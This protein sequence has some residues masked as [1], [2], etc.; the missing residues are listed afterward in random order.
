M[1]SLSAGYTFGATETVTNSKLA[2]LVNDGGVTG[3]TQA[4]I[5]AA[6]GLVKV[7]TSA[8]S[9]TDQL[10]ID[11]NSTPVLVRYYN[12]SLTAWVP[13]GELALYTNNS[14]QTGS[15]GRVLILDTSSSNA[16]TYTTTSGDTKFLGV[17]TGSITNGSSAPVVSHGNATVLLTVSAS[18]GCYLRTATASG[19]ADPVVNTAAGVFGFVTQA[20]TASARSHIFG[21]D[22]NGTIDQTANYTWTGTHTHNGTVTLSSAVTATNWNP[23]IQIVTTQAGAASALGNTALPH[24]DSIPQNT[25]GNAIAALDTSITPKNTANILHIEGAVTFTQS[26]ASDFM[27]LALFQDSTAGALRATTVGPVDLGASSNQIRIFHRMA[28]GTTSSTTF[29]LRIG[30]AGGASAWANAEAGGNNQVF[31][32]VAMSYLRVMETRT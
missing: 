19:K 10:W 32:G 1:A 15:L 3:V 28:A 5:A 24:D 18:A 16:Y 30:N 8:P 9:D 27:S 25:E 7:S 11:T 22:P 21:I 2:S 6:E 20:G 23:I 29:K 13:V 17:E 4:D 14:G 26:G 12:S 31:G